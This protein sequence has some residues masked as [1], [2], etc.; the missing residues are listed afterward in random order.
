[1]TAVAPQLDVELP[2]ESAKASCRAAASE[3]RDTQK[4]KDKF[5]LEDTKREVVKGET[6]RMGP[7]VKGA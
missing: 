3:W 5:E 7:K 2:T 1:M 4:N 6:Y